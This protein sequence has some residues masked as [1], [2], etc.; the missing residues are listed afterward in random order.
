M[1]DIARMRRALGLALIAALAPSAHAARLAAPS[2]AT[3]GQPVQV[4]LRDVSVY[5]P[6]TRFTRVGTT[7]VVDY[8]YAPNAFVARPDFG[9]APVRLGELVPGNYTIQARLF[10]MDEPAAAPQVMTQSLAVAPPDG[11]GI[12]LIPRAPEAFAPT[13]VMIRSAAYFDPGS[14]RVTTN[15]SSIR[16]DFDYRGDAFVGG[17]VPAGTTSFAAVRLPALAPGHYT[18][19]GWGRDKSK[20]APA[21][22]YFSQ[23]FTVSS[24]VQVVEYYAE[25]LDHY[26][27]TAAPDEVALLD[28]GGMGGW[29]RTGQ[30]FKAWLRMGDAPPNAKPVCR[31]YATGPNSHFYTGS[32]EDC[33][34]LKA[35]ESSQRADAQSRGEP[36][37]G[38]AFENIAFYALVPENGQCMPGTTPVYRAYNDRAVDNDTNHRF[39]SDPRQRVAMVMTWLDEGVA[40][41]SPP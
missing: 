7:I 33:Q 39:T 14:M 30:R 10:R 29:K 41:C 6:A 11:W 36:F 15:G 21:E 25:S 13:D 18:V 37:A 2:L 4:E 32:A 34:Y 17:P 16:V 38:W 40:F 1:I 23:A 19:E 8:E 20:G 28:G 3:Y 22:R 27:M 5:L 35:L 12:Y 24:A 26:F 9:T 31:F